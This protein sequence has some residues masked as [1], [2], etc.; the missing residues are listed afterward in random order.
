MTSGGAV[1]EQKA[2]ARRSDAIRNRDRILEVAAIVFAD[3][4]TASLN[5]IAQRTGIGPGTLYRHFPNR[6][7]LLLAVYQ[8]EVAALVASVDDLL[9]HHEPLE[10]FRIWSRR[11]AAQSRVKHGL[12]DALTG[13]AAQA[14]IGAT[15][16][17]VS[18]AIRQLL[19]AASA[20]GDVVAGIDPVD[21]VLLLSA[22]WR[23]PAGEGGLRQADR[24]LELIVAGLQSAPPS[25]TA[26]S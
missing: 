19:D 14:V 21:V 23:V 9:E 1:D 17:P 12:G 26:R 13:A 20:A 3:D 2:Q 22:L 5:T 11:L 16:A 4:P 15:W 7:T 18:G 6:E 8:E 25:A 10:A 24:L